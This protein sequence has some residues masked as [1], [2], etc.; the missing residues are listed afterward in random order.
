MFKKL[1]N[2]W[3]ISETEGNVQFVQRSSWNDILMYSPDL[4]GYRILGIFE[5]DGALIM[6]LRANGK[7][8]RLL[9]IEQFEDG[10]FHLQTM[11]IC[12]IDLGNILMAFCNPDA[13][14]TDRQHQTVN[15]SGPK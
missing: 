6:A 13:E 1:K 12:S 15:S 9:K 10:R 11:T 5:D 4:R 7:Q 8:P 2:G 3:S 14:E